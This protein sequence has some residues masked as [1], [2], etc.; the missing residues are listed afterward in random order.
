MIARDRL[1][2]A[3][4]TM[5][6]ATVVA[7]LLGVQGCA[8]PST[9]P[10][11]G[12]RIARIKKELRAAQLDDSV[13]QFNEALAARNEGDA[14]T[15]ERIRQHA[16]CE[17]STALEA[18]GADGVQVAALKDACEYLSRPLKRP[19]RPTPVVRTASKQE[20]AAH[21]PIEDET[22]SESG[23]P[24]ADPPSADVQA[25]VKPAK[26]CG[27]SDVQCATSLD[28]KTLA[29][30]SKSYMTVDRSALSVADDVL[31]KAWAGARAQASAAVRAGTSAKPGVDRLWNVGVTP[32]SSVLLFSAF[33]DLMAVLVDSKSGGPPAS[34][35]VQIDNDSIDAVAATD[36]LEDGNRQVVVTY[37]TSGQ[38]GGE[39]NIAVLSPGKAGF[40]RIL[41]VPLSAISE[42]YDGGLS[43]F[44]EYSYHVAGANGGPRLVG[45]KCQKRIRTGCRRVPKSYSWD[46]KTYVPKS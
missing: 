13:R 27:E 16:F 7:V 12:D 31:A 45:V 34:G 35:L 25:V 29:E 37:S 2:R 28:S 33:G 42:S 9:V 18:A 38:H 23:A 46:G 10:S 3:W 24:S 40:S 4:S 15:A 17:N 26:L 20:E 22:S 39:T 41:T 36:L 32:H 11:T 14:L 21:S 19:V 1:V 5:G 44:E 30:L 43:P 8:T 6:A